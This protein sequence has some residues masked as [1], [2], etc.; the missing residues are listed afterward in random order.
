MYGD[1]RIIDTILRIADERGIS[2]YRLS[3]LSGIPQS[4]IRNMKRRGNSPSL[5]NYVALCV[6]AGIEPSSLLPKPKDVFYART[7]EGIDYM[8]NQFE[9]MVLMEIRKIPDEQKHQELLL[10]QLRTTIDIIKNVSGQ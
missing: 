2:I 10:K 9:E 3:K 4:T 7:P 1:E 5:D 6:A 8:I